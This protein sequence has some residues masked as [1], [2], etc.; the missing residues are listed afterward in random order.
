M[1]EAFFLI[2]F[3]FNYFCYNLHIPKTTEELL[4]SKHIHFQ[5]DFTHEDG[6]EKPIGFV[7]IKAYKPC[8]QEYHEVKEIPKKSTKQKGEKKSFCYQS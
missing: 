6:Q 7:D 5:N 2:Y 1:K 3:N 4:W 8:V